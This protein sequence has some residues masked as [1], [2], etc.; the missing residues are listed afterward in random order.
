[1]TQ[2]QTSYRSGGH[3]PWH[4]DAGQTAVAFARWLGYTEV[5]RVTS[6]SVHGSDALIGVGWLDTQEMQKPGTVAVVHLKRYG[7]DRDAPWEVV[8]TNDSYLTV[9]TP[10]Y[11]STVSSPV[12]VGGRITGVD[13]ALQV[14]VLGPTGTVLGTAGPLAAGGEKQPWTTTVKVSGGSG[15]VVTIAVSTGG[16]LKTVERFAVTGVRLHS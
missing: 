14:K 13:E 15:Q 7:T 16:H 2:W 5:D 8:G 10:R 4:L 9:S 12:T 3:Q 11:G 1:V 6:T